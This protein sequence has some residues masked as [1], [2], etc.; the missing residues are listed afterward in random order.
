MM[1]NKRA[2]NLDEMQNQKL[3]KLEEYGFWIVFW[4]LLVSIIV[5]L[6]AGAGIKEVIG[7]TVVFLI[8]SVYLAV[9]TLQNGLW[10]GSSVPS[11][12][13][14]ALVSI[15]PAAVIGILDVFKMIRGNGISQ[16]ALPVT[17]GI[18]AAAYA[19]CFIILEL[20]RAVSRK[21]RSELDDIDDESGE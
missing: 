5:Q 6:T 8:G 10:T 17:V 14:N 1:R 18:M 16:S 4:A 2:G 11:R 21:R 9:T 3:L 20:F 7:E 19:G 13:G 12:K 15:I